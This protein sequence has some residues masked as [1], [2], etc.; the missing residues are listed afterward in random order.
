MAEHTKEHFA[1]YL[2]KTLE[3]ITVEEVR[4]CVSGA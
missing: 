4:V 3:A 1:P 2:Q